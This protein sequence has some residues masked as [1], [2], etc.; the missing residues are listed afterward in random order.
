LPTFVQ[1]PRVREALDATGKLLG[2]VT[3]NQEEIH[4]QVVDV[5]LNFYRAWRLVQQDRRRSTKHLY[6]TGMLRYESQ[7]GFDESLLSAKIG[8]DGE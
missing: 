6:V 1:Q 8:E 5:V 3:Y 7:N 4:E 2:G